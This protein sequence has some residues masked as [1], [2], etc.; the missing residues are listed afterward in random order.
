M[1]LGDAGGQLAERLL[2]V[3]VGLGTCFQPRGLAAAVGKMR[4]EGAGLQR[5]SQKVT[6]KTLK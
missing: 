6:K 1:V 5:P 2:H 4:S 3:L